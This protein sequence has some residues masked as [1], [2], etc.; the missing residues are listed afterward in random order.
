MN[1]RLLA[2]FAQEQ[3]WQMQHYPD[4]VQP[5]IQSS[6]AWHC[7]WPSEPD[8]KLL[9]A[10][11]FSSH[12]VIKQLACDDGIARSPTAQTPRRIQIGKERHTGQ[13]YKIG[14]SFQAI[15]KHIGCNCNTF[16]LETE[17]RHELRK[18]W[19]AVCECS[20][21]SICSIFFLRVFKGSLV[22]IVS[23]FSF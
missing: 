2:A 5:L 12:C 8:P 19:S 22:V 1:Q 17:I 7:T 14:P 3:I 20:S 13:Q 6:N 16:N 9:W 4:R 23:P 21:K 15:Q 10:L 11:T 18:L